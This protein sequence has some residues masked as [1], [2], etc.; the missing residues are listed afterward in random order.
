MT[1]E[2]PASQP[3]TQYKGLLQR[4]M[5]ENCFLESKK[6]KKILA[7]KIYSSVL[8]LYTRKDPFIL[9][10][11]VIYSVPLTLVSNWERLNMSAP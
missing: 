11:Q 4:L 3:S 8:S 9:T 6:S 7:F 10:T 5:T 1:D 2:L